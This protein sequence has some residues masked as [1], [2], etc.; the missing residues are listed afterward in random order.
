MLLA[1]PIFFAS[2]FLLYLE[3]V[4]HAVVIK[5]PVIPVCEEVAVLIGFR[6]YEV[7]FFGKVCCGSCIINLSLKN[8]WVIM[9]RKTI[10][11]IPV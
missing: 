5:D 10:D 4:A 11:T 3:I 9:R 6:L 7:A 2:A 8:G 1:L